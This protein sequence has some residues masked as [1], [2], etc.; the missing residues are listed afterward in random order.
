MKNDRLLMF[1]EEKC[2]PCVV[3]EPIVVKLE[4]ELGAKIDRLEVW[5]NQSNRQLLDKYAGFA[6]VPFFYNEKTDQ[7][8]SGETDYETL[9]SW[10]RLG[11]PQGETSTK[12]T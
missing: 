1:Y 12:E 4:R 11:S 9:K 7:K 5:Y 2:D 8:I 3:M 10:A 6:T